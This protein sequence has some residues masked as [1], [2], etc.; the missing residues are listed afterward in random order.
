LLAEL[1]FVL[2]LV[3]ENAQE[4]WLRKSD[5]G[6]IMSIFDIICFDMFVFFSKKNCAFL[7][8]SDDITNNIL[9]MLLSK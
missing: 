1:I 4:Y 2:L 3:T 7:F 8:L 9:G 6:E 5:Y